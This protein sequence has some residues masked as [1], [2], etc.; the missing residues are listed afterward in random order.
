MV[1]SEMRLLD[2]EIARAVLVGDGRLSSSDD[3]I[4]EQ[5][6]RPIWTDSDLQPLRLVTVAAGPDSDQ[7]PAFIRAAIKARRT[8]KIRRTNP[9]YNRR[10]T[11][12]L[13]ME[14]TT[15]TS[16]TILLQL[17]TALRVKET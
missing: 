5:N 12:C 15:D 3:K 17:A 14:D 7:K 11:D 6:I 13:L 10:C 2:E 1:K 8:I 16:S 9:I 4:N